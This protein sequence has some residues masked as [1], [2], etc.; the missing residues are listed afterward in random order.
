MPIF[1]DVVL[2]TSVCHTESL[3]IGFNCILV[4]NQHAPFASVSDTDFFLPNPTHV[5]S[6]KQ[7][8]WQLAKSP[9]FG[10]PGQFPPPPELAMKTFSVYHRLNQDTGKLGYCAYGQLMHCVKDVVWYAQVLEI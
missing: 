10:F 8:F 9:I 5:I 3:R 4:F 1:Q 7:Y 2:N 6:S